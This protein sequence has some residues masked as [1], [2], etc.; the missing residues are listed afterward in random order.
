[1]TSE[2]NHEETC[3]FF[4]K[5]GYFDYPKESIRFFKQDRLPLVLE[6]GTLAL[7]SSCHLNFAANGNGGVFTSLKSH[8]LLD[9]MKSIGC[10][11]VFLF[12]VDNALAKVCDPSFIGFM[13]DK[14]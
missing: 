5:H 8:H 6:D 13:A 14:M 4:E 10:E 11:F 7:K 3:D 1:M 12:G 9:E 2:D